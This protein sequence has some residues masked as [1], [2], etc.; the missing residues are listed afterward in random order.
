MASGG[1]GVAVG[2]VGGGKAVRAGEGVGPSDRGGGPDTGGG[3]G[4]GRSQLWR[5]QRG[6]SHQNQL[7]VVSTLSAENSHTP[8]L[9]QQHYLQHSLPQHYG[10]RVVVHNETHK[11]HCVMIW[12][13][14]KPEMIADIHCYS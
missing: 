9:R 2:A 8:L 4:R 7:K 3:G 14:C 1:V 11:T 5:G 10:V 12:H 6:I 13:K